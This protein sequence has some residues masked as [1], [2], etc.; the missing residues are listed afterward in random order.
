MNTRVSVSVKQVLHSINQHSDRL[1]LLFFFSSVERILSIGRLILRTG[2]LYP[3]NYL[4]LSPLDFDRRDIFSRTRKILDL[5]NRSYRQI[6]VTVFCSIEFAVGF[7]FKNLARILNQ[8]RNMNLTYNKR[9][10]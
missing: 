8:L 2:R 9:T 7:S 10:C 1:T 5:N 3:R 6:F 4:I